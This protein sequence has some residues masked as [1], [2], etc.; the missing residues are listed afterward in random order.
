MSIYY[1][2]PYCQG[3]RPRIV[4][5]KKYQVQ[6]IQKYHENYIFVKKAHNVNRFQV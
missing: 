6:K 3:T 1:E 4:K 2:T 5:I